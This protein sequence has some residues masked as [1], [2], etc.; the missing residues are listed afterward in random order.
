MY[1]LNT[2][3]ALDTI[4]LIVC[5]QPNIRGVLVDDPMFA[6]FR[7]SRCGSLSRGELFYPFDIAGGKVPC[8]AFI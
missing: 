3:A 5:K 8:W 1:N 6:I 7:W 4:S 2:F